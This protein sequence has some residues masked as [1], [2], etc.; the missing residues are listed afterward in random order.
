MLYKLIRAAVDN[1]GE[2]NEVVVDTGNFPTDRFVVEGIA[3]ERGLVLRW[4]DPDP[5]AGVG[6]DDVRAVLGP[7]TALVLLSHVAFRS[8]EVADLPTSTAAAHEA[9]A[10]VLWDL[11]HSAG[12]LDVQLDYPGVGLAVGRREDSRVGQAGVR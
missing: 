11:C 4:I 1:A 5:I 3:A 2:R 6:V 9:G 7:R 10:L 8:G 12:A